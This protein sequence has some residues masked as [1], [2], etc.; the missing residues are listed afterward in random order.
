[1]PRP[2]CGNCCPHPADLATNPMRCGY[3]MVRE[4]RRQRPG[5][6]P[7]LPLCGKVTCGKEGY[8]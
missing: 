4:R 8:A 5:Q 2:G 6:N 1:M 7:V 3:C